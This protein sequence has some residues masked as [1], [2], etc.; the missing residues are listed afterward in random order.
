MLMRH[1]VDK[2][3]KR[4]IDEEIRALKMNETWKLVSLGQCSVDFDFLTLPGLL[5]GL[6]LAVHDADL[7][8]GTETRYKGE[9][10]SA[11]SPKISGP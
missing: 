3:W 1:L 5:C 9:R 10:S 11:R 8:Q 6:L 4:A 2:E 7:H